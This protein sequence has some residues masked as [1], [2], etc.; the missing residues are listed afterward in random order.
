MVSLIIDTFSSCIL[1]GYV[2]LLQI[3]MLTL[4]I[5]LALLQLASNFENLEFRARHNYGINFKYSGKILNDVDYWLHSFELE[6]PNLI[7]GKI[8]IGACQNDSNF[9]CFFRKSLLK[10]FNILSNKIEQDIEKNKQIN[11]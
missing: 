3:K 5:F 8:N 7:V 11:R 9:F 10:H 6:T 2:S 1:I 4:F